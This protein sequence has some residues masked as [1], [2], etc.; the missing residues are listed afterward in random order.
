MALAQLLEDAGAV[1]RLPQAEKQLGVAMT[2]AR[3]FAVVAVLARREAKDTKAGRPYLRWHLTG[4]PRASSQ[5][6]WRVCA[7]RDCIPR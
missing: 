2:A 7:L 5:E 1:L 4:T 6:V 3:G